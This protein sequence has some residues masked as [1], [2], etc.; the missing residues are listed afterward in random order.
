MPSRL[1][2]ALSDLLPRVGL[3]LDLACGGGRNSVY[4]ARRGL[5][6]V[7]VDRAWEGL[8][9]G[10]ELAVQAGVTVSWVR[11][12]L[13]GFHTPSETFDVIVCFY[14][15]DPSLYPI[16]RA[17]LH[18][19][20]LLIY[21]TFTHDQVRFSKGPKNPAYLLGPGELLNAFGD[22]NIVSYRETWSDRG[23]AALVARKPLQVPIPISEAG[24]GQSHGR[25]V[26]LRVPGFP[27]T[28][29]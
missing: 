22:W 27:P 23:E 17:S 15:R 26:R 12:D 14:Y 10:K 13:E 29:S 2:I 4:L 5:Q 20:G 9:R 11:A 16:I 1:L 8:Q 19:G 28:P 24:L 21:Q 3:A 18:R 25:A 6:V 7:G